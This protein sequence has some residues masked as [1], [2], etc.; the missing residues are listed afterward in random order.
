MSTPKRT[1][2]NAAATPPRTPSPQ[3]LTTVTANKTILRAGVITAAPRKRLTAPSASKAKKA[4]AAAPKRGHKTNNVKRGDKVKHGAIAP[5]ARSGTPSFCASSGNVR[6]ATDVARKKA[7]ARPAAGT[8]HGLCR[9]GSPVSLPSRPA[10]PELASETVESASGSQ[11]RV[12]SATPTSSSSSSSSSDSSD[13]SMSDETRTVPGSRSADAGRSGR[14]ARSKDMSAATERYIPSGRSPLERQIQAA[15]R[16]HGYRIEEVPGDGD[17]AIH[18]IKRV[19]PSL[20]DSVAQIRANMVSRLLHDVQESNLYEITVAAYE[21]EGVDVVEAMSKAERKLRR[22]FRKYRPIGPRGGEWIDNET[23]VGMARHYDMDVVILNTNASWTVVEATPGQAAPRRAHI[24]LAGEHYR[25]LVPSASDSDDASAAI[26]AAPPQFLATASARLT[27]RRACL[28]A[29]ASGN[30][31]VPATDAVDQLEFAARSATTSAAK[32]ATAQMLVQRVAAAQ[33][34]LALARALVPEPDPVAPPPG[35][36]KSTTT[37]S[38]RGKDSSS[39]GRGR[40]GSGRGRGRGRGQGQG[41]GRGRGRGKS[42]RERSSSSLPPSPSLNNLTGQDLEAIVSELVRIARAVP[43]VEAKWRACLE[44][45]LESIEDEGT[46]A[47]ISD[48]L[49]STDGLS[50]T[51]PRSSATA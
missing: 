36:R 31:L 19:L 33:D 2:A 6:G 32:R 41:R 23:L 9:A 18:S 25:P 15:A 43:S 42:A 20:T 48:L 14:K 16:V 17:C 27:H 11:K 38:P 26:A 50:T 30:G 1:Y 28:Q 22:R 12:R 37:A 7:P 13:S 51:L 44:R 10:S 5:R 4:P 47:A 34:R 8:I 46:K 29:V 39:T 24:A 35:R 21:Q 3:Q 45:D 40:G 49:N